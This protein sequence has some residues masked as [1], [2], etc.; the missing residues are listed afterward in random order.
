MIRNHLLLLSL[1]A[2]WNGA[3]Q[4]PF[5]LSGDYFVIPIKSTGFLAMTFVVFLLPF[6]SFSQEQKEVEII[7]ADYLKMQES[8]IIQRVTQLAARQPKVFQIVESTN[9]RQLH[10]L[11]KSDGLNDLRAAYITPRFT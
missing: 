11:Q 1:R 6:F 4:S 5:N 10:R 8:E 7:N 3:K 2:E 9:L